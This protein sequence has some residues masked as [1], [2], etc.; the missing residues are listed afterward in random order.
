MTLKTLKKRKMEWISFGVRSV[1]RIKKLY[2]P[3]LAQHW[4]DIVSMSKKSPADKPAGCN[5]TTE[6][7]NMTCD[8]RNIHQKHQQRATQ[9]T[10]F[11]APV[12]HN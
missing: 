11:C 12:G 6:S 9:E 4:T 7:L 2:G 10:G 8:L 5:R 3:K 1:G